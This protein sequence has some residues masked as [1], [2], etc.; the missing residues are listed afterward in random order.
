MVLILAFV[1]FIGT[2]QGQPIYMLHLSKKKNIYIYI[3]I[4]CYLDHFVVGALESYVE[5][6]CSPPQHK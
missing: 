3:Y 2:T 1:A 5:I 6:D 4:C